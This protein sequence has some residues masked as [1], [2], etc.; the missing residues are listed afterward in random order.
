MADIII[1][2]EELQAA[3]DFLTAFL[4]EQVPEASFK[5]GSAVRDLAVKAF[6][7]IFAYLKGEGV[8][9]RDRTSLLKIQ[10]FTDADDIAQATDEIMSNWFVGRKDGSYSHIITTLHFTKRTAVRILGDMEFWRTNTLVFFVDSVTDPYVIAE[11]DMLPQY[12]SRGVLVDYTVDV[13]MIAG[14]VGDDYN[15]DPGVFVK[16][17]GSSGLPY[18][19]YA[20]NLASTDDGK[21]VE[22][23][24]ELIARAGTAI[25]VRNLIN[26]RSCDTVLQDTYPAITQ[27]LSIGLG[28][29]EMVRDLKTEIASHIRLHTGGFYDTYIGLGLTT[30]EESGVV[31]GYFPRPDNKNVVFRDPQLRYDL[32]FTFTA[33]GAKVGYILF[34][35]SG[36]KGSPRGYPIV[37]V[38]ESELLVSSAV[39]FDEA[40]DELVTTDPLVYSIGYTSPGFND[41]DLEP[42]GFVYTRVAAQS[43]DP[44]YENVPVGT[45]RHIQEKGRIVLTGRPIQDIE[46]VELVDPA[47]SDSEITD[48]ATGTIIFAT[49]VNS[50]PVKVL[51]PSLT[52]YRVQ[53]LNP[54]SAQSGDAVTLIQVGYID[55]TLPTP[56]DTLGDLDGKT[57]RVVYRTF[58]GFD[59]M[60]SRVRDRDVRVLA[61]NHLIKARSPIW[62]EFTIPY[63]L[64]PTA[65]DTVDEE[66]AAVSLAAHVN[67]FN[68]DDD[69]DMSDIATKFRELYP[70]VGVVYPF[71][72]YY[73]LQAPDGQV[74]EFVTTDVTS[75][76]PTVDNGVTL[77]NGGDIVAPASLS[78]LTTITT[79]EALNSWY[80]L[81]GISDRT[82]QY[83]T[84]VVRISFLLKGN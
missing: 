26:N 45:S 80:G 13:P 44:D 40:Y 69:L 9:I 14:G 65:T 5:P 10:D 23:T 3:E 16:V 70:D 58:A 11:G 7:Y 60:H 8:L 33:I 71:D 48:T 34:I 54:A 18:F 21:G 12:D 6:T 4:T 36:I 46:R 35:H 19:S 22:T 25:T 49:R 37:E 28:E 41:V 57:L 84:T 2:D 63:K 27:T 74:A 24:E 51:E 76:F 20:E 31:G 50:D 43:V 55:P 47:A 68:P 17:D 32:G 38:R 72:I 62:I 59:S 42:A 82:V 29:P 75:I 79:L 77:E 66:E 15:I 1:S 64:K 53:V 78:P 39:A 67:N 56:T 81:M 52:Q 61:A 83:R 73:T 30:V